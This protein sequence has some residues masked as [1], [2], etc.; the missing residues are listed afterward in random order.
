MRKPSLLSTTAARAASTPLVSSIKMQGDAPSLVACHS[1]TRHPLEGPK[2]NV[3]LPFWEAAFDLVSTVSSK[4]THQQ[5][6]HV[7]AG[8]FGIG[9]AVKCQLT[10]LLFGSILSVRQKDE[11]ERV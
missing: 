10:P 9:E 5:R 3:R 2:A 7:P 1:G 4:R 6:E 8:R 11:G